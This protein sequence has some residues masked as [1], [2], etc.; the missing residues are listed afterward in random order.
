MDRL[1]KNIINQL[2]GG[3]P[4][5]DRP[6]QQIAGQLD[7]SESEIM[8][9]I[10]SMLDDGLLTRFGPMFN[11]DKMGGIFSLCAL[12]APQ[13]KFDK[14]ADI[15]NAFP[16]VAH[17]Y[18]RAHHLNMWFVI[19]AQSQAKLNNTI[20]S[21]EQATGLKVYNFPKQ[22]EFYVNLQLSA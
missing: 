5:C 21:I 7:A 6:F 9:R 8:A 13:D 3:F 14:I 20:Q 15:V 1:D 12:H 18:A 2:Q 10:Q 16:E 19:A 22:K 17:N 4:V 11:I